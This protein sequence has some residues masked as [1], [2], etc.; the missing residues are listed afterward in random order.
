MRAPACGP[1]APPTRGRAAACSGRSA[2][3]AST[4]RRSRRATNETST[5]S[6]LRRATIAK[7]SPTKETIRAGPSVCQSPPVKEKSEKLSFS[8]PSQPSR[9]SRCTRVASSQA[10]RVDEHER[11]RGQ[12]GRRP[13]PDRHGQTLPLPPAGDDERHDQEDARVLRARREARHDPRPGQPVRDHQ[14]E[15]S[16]D[17]GLERHVGDGGVRVG[18][19]RRLH[20]DERAADRARDVAVRAPPQPPGGG[21]GATPEARRSRCAP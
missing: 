4:G 10:S 12:E 19:A 1:R 2:P 5:R 15:R 6:A 3:E 21:H 17:A 18:D 8:K 11:A 7:P 9:A 13:Q 16:G 14:R 20:G